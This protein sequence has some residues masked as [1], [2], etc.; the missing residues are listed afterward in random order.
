[1]DND[2]IQMSIVDGIYYCYYKSIVINL[3]I[4]KEIVK[5]RQSLT[6]GKKYPFIIDIRKVKGFKMDAVS[7]LS[8]NESVDDVIKMAIVVNS[9]F[10][11]LLYSLFSMIIPPRIPA[12][13]FV[14]EK[15][16]K[17]WINSTLK[18]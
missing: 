18:K 4:A 14:N 15:D 16:A 2:Y 13:L 1:M 11:V 6:R 7:Y 5:V 3:R 8:G 17:T 9:K 12:K 10:I